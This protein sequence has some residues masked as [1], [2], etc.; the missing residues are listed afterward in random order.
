MLKK[1]KIKFVAVIMTFVTISFAAV[2]GLALFFTRQNMKQESIRHMQALL[3]SGREPAAAAP[4]RPEDPRLPFFMV[5]MRPPENIIL[6]GGGFFDLSDKETLRSLIDTALSADEPVGVIRDSE[7]RYLLSPDRRRIVFADISQENAMLSHV[8]KNFLLLG[9]AGYAGLFAVSLLLANWVVRPVAQAWHEQKRFIADASHELKTPLTVILTNAE[10]LSDPQAGDREKQRF[11]DNILVMSG[12][13]RGLV[14]SLLILARLDSHTLAVRTEELNFSKLVSDAHLPFEALFF[15]KGLELV[16]DIENDLFV[17][18]DR[19]QLAQA[20]EILLDNACKYSAPSVPV[21]VSL[22][23]H[24]NQCVFSVSGGGTPLS[25]Q[26]RKNV[27][28]RFYRLDSARTGSGS[29]GLGLAIAERIVNE[30]GG[31][32]WAESSDKTNTFGFSLS[33]ARLSPR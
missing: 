1:L 22:K 17:R 24:K 11:T 9:L 23:R 27:F 4:G 33:A 2:L 16:C 26:E 29:Y 12:R 13:M 31:T 21:A 7:L 32:I 3:S 5:E 25:P 19:Q 30:H 6:S 18:G 10:M 14:E 20:A 15:E 8:V 28:Q